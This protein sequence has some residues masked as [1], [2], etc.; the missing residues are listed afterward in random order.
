TVEHDYW[1]GIALQHEG[2]LDEVEAL[3]GSWT[4][5]HGKGHSA[6]RERLRR[7][8]LLLRADAD[9]EGT[10]PALQRELSVVLDDRAEVVV[11]AQR[12][13]TRLE[14]STIDGAA[15]LQAELRRGDLRKIR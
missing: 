14:P 13:P 1:H 7:R 8:Q 3:L 9:L 4:Q 5:R 12:Y 6:E 2:R 11:K 10:G 15:L